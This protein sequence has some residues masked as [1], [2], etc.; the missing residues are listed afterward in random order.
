M[1]TLALLLVLA[2]TAV[3][4]PAKIGPGTYRPIFPASP[5]EK[6]VPV[7]AFRLD[8]TPVTNAQFRA[9]VTQHPEWQRGHVKPL[10]A[11]ERYLDGFDTAP[12][13]APVVRVSW[14]AARAYCASVG[15]RL[16]VEREWELAAAASATVKDASRDPKFQARVIDWYTQLAPAVLPDV[17]GA[18]N[19]WGVRD[20]HGLVW[21]WIEDFNSALVDADSRK[22]DRNVFCGGAG[23]TSRDASAYATFMRIAFR[24]SLEARSTTSLLGFR[25][26]YD[27]QEAR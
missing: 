20:M 21:E 7:A 27:I 19:A 13:H 6:E 18:P 17:G 16:P 15:G 1:K 24:S 8:R 25:C 23:A 11:D 4:G 3:A 10:L 26:A 5:A 12:P 9:F 2:G 22:P 14:F